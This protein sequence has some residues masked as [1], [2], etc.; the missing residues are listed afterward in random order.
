MKLPEG[1]SQ[2]NLK[3]LS[4]E[5]RPT[6]VLIQSHSTFLGS[7]KS[8]MINI[9]QMIYSTSKNCLKGSN[10]LIGNKS[11]SQDFRWTSS[12][13][14]YPPRES[15]QWCRRESEQWCRVVASA[16]EGPKEISILEQFFRS[17][18]R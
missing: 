8:A 17:R 2:L 11:D 12:S 5:K 16:M 9:Q 13:F 15:E 7:L 4:D 18:G 10:Q 1:L 6:R 3:I 14:A